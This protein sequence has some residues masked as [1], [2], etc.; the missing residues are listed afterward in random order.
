MHA[1]LFF[2]HHPVA[3]VSA[4][5]AVSRIVPRFIPQAGCPLSHFTLRVLQLHHSQLLFIVHCSAP[6]IGARILA[7]RSSQTEGASFCPRCRSDCGQPHPHHSSPH[8]SRNAR[9]ASAATALLSR[10]GWPC[11]VATSHSWPR[12]DSVVTVK[13][14]RCLR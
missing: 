11:A 2:M 3:R 8:R 10:W 6:C 5:P 9:R 14:C 4:R 7:F 13:A 1:L 12:L